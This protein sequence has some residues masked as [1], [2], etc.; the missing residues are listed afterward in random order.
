MY[1]RRSQYK[2]FSV[3]A[4]FED[5]DPCISMNIHHDDRIINSIFNYIK[6]FLIVF[7]AHPNINIGV[8][9]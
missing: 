7:N 5:N 9:S 6:H 4:G 3:N 8:L 2:Y 1:V